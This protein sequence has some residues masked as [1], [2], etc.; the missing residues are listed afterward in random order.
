MRWA[1]GLFQRLAAEGRTVF[2]SSHLMSEMENTAERLIVIGQGRLI[3]DQTVAEFRGP[4]RRIQCHGANVTV[5]TPDPAAL[6]AVLTEAGAFVRTAGDVLTVT[7]LNAARVGE[8]AFTHHVMVHEIIS[9]T[10]TLEDAW[11]AMTPILCATTVGEGD[12]RHVADV[13][14]DLGEQVRHHGGGT[15]DQRD[16][17]GCERGA[18]R[19]VGGEM[20]HQDIGGQ[21]QWPPP[22]PQ[23]GVHHRLAQHQP[24]HRQRP[25]ASQPQR[26]GHGDGH[27][28]HQPAGQPQILVR[29]LEDRRD[30]G[31]HRVVERHGERGA[32]ADDRAREPAAAPVPG[33]SRHHERTRQMCLSPSVVASGFAAC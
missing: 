32:Q 33:G 30:Q 2:V 19:P 17:G 24:E 6:V 7:G 28:H 14:A 31:G 22:L 4:Q 26:C 10:G 13:V 1:R 20:T 9:H 8:L 15:D 5:R 21:P 16:T 18:P 25:A 29:R 12:Q 3:A 27:A 23:Q 11:M